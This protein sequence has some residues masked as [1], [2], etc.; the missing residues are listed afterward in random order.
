MDNKNFYKL[1]KKIKKLSKKLNI[2]YYELLDLYKTL[3]IQYY[4]QKLI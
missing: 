3:I 1:K 4:T 2:N